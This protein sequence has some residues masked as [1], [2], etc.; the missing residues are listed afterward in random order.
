MVPRRRLL[1]ISHET[2]SAHA[3][4]ALLAFWSLSAKKKRAASPTP[5]ATTA[6]K[7]TRRRDP[8]GDRAHEMCYASDSQ[9]AK[10]FAKT[11]RRQSGSH[12]F[13]DADAAVMLSCPLATYYL[14][15]YAMRAKW[16]LGNV[17]ALW[18]CMAGTWMKC[19]PTSDRF[20][21]ERSSRPRAGWCRA[22]STARDGELARSAD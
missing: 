4:M 18:T 14:G 19:A 6:E 10:Y 13:A 9:K 15:G 2:F 17:D 22:C 7:A 8:L 1:P 3:K 5:A 20:V 11:Q 21:E 16:N 12:G